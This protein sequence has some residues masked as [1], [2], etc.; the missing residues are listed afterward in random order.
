MNRH[1]KYSLGFTDHVLYGLDLTS[2]SRRNVV[3]RRGLAAAHQQLTMRAW[4][5]LKINATG[6]NRAELATW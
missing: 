4:R 2:S 5:S 3:E 1:E 6:K